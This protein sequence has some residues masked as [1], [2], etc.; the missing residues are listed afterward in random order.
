MADRRTIAKA[1]VDSDKFLSLSVS[2]QALYFHLVI[3]ADD[4]G[5]IRNPKRLGRIVNAR[6]YDFESLYRYG[7]I[8]IEGSSVVITHWKEHTNKGEI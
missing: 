5:V 6:D 3:R 8:T 2:T 1:V 7:F 4:N